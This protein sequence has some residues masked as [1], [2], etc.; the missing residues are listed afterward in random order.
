M[1]TIKNCK[2]FKG[3][4][5]LQQQHISIEN[6]F[7]TE[8]GTE[9]PEKGTV[10]DAK[11]SYVHAGFIELQI[12]GSGGNLFSAY[13]SKE[14]LQQMDADLISKGTTGFMACVAT[15]TMQVVY[16]CIDAA[17]AYRNE[18]QGF[19]GL[20]L[21]G[22]YLNPKRLGAHVPEYVHK[23][24]L[25]EVKK[26][27]EYAEGSIRVM[28]VAAEL[29]DVA[30]IDYLLEQGIILSLGHSD[31]NFEQATAAYDKGFR[32]TTH[33]FNAMPPIHHRSPGLPVAVFSH[34]A[35]M[36]SI[37]ADGNHVDFEV[38]KMSYKL[39]KDRLFLITDAVTECGIGP[40][41][42]QLRGNKFTT[43]DGT[44]SGSSITML[45]AVKN[46]VEYCEI[47]LSKALD[48]ASL[49]PARVIKTDHSSGSLAVGKKADLIFL[50]D[51]LALQKV[52]IGGVEHL[53]HRN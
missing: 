17:K 34:P 29:Q 10:I 28:T 31:A 46:C 37:I 52:F 8:I 16:E 14:T 22:P 48:M 42:H 39:M 53:I 19:L 2:L 27:V 26:L 30:V 49:H 1:I 40:Y 43:P 41:Q 44:L 4:E 45:E 47:P 13:P 51:E 3:A 15:N 12:Y 36:A 21:E 7:I 18:A 23:A 11:G 6:G 9:I 50:D 5:L 38:I 33:L 35:A 24:S 25:E 20:H 32:T